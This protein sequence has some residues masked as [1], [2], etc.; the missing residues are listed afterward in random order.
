MILPCLLIFLSASFVLAADDA[1][2]NPPSSD[3]IAQRLKSLEES[4]SFIEQKL[5]K[6]IDDLI[7]FRALDDVAQI[8]RVRYTGPPPRSGSGT[9]T[10]AA[11]NEV[12]ISAYTFLPKKYLSR[13]KIPLLLFVH[14]EI[15]GEAR[16]EEEAHIIREL[17]EQGYA[18]I[19]P[20]Y[21]G[22][23]GY[24]GDF[25]RLIDYGGLETEDV[26]AGKQWMVEHY[27]NIDPQRVGIL[28]W[29]H[30]GLITLMNIFEHPAAYQ[31]A[32]AGAPV[33]DLAARL[34]YM[35]EDYA[36]LFSA[37]YHLGKTPAQDPEEYRRRS[38][39]S[40]AAKLQTP[41][42]LHANT[43][44]EDVRFVEI[45]HLLGALQAAGKKFEHKIYT[46]APGGHYFNRLDT[47]FAKESRAEVYRYLAR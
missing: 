22:S 13:R 18:V 40:Q 43:S 2:T 30:G 8:G 24:G 17:I 42:L 25:W 33:C 7:W 31:V 37:P 32:Y 1:R 12:I 14:P 38:P 47:R 11:S 21:R 15:H 44:D 3:P 28:G 41:L 4:L 39:I 46:N 27:R 23:V 5:T 35:G 6:H 45:E 9:H 16:P 20:D 10:A 36:E 34:A 26:F 29:S 19:A